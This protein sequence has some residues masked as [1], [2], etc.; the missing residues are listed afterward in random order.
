MRVELRREPKE[1]YLGK[2]SGRARITKQL[3]RLDYVL[4]RAVTL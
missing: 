3:P 1:D 2:K 4:S